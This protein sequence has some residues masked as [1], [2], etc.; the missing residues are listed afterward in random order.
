MSNWPPRPPQFN[1]PP[2]YSASPSYP[3]RGGRGG[4]A[5]QPALSPSPTLVNDPQTRRNSP[6]DSEYHSWPLPND[7]G[8]DRP[9]WLRA[10]NVRHFRGCSRDGVQTAEIEECGLLEL[11]MVSRDLVMEPGAQR[12]DDTTEAGNG[13]G[14]DER[15]GQRS[16]D[17]RA[18][19]DRDGQLGRTRDATAPQQAASTVRT[20]NFGGDPPVVVPY[21]WPPAPNFEGH[22]T[23]RSPPG[24]RVSSR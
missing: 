15:R 18:S 14:W 7:P 1:P 9:R 10:N 22:S 19:M 21:N 11:E 17:R 24:Q 5:Y 2:A 20:I 3:W 13:R 8:T 23:G 12:Q 6:S 16:P 4:Y